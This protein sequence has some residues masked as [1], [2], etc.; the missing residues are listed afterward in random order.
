MNEP[1]LGTIFMFGG[2]YA[3]KGYA[4]CQGQL[5]Q[6]TQNMALFSVIGTTYG[7]DGQ[8]TFALPKL[9]GPEGTIYIMAVTGMFPSRE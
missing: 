5:L 4:M 2:N 7:G 9:S 6:I 3:P 1:F 8:K